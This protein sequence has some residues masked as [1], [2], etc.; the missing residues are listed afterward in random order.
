MLGSKLNH[1]STRPP[2]ERWKTLG[3]L[4]SINPNM[5]NHYASQSQTCQLLKILKNFFF[6]NKENVKSGAIRLNWY[7]KS[8]SIIERSYIYILY[9]IYVEFL[10]SHFNDLSKFTGWAIIE[11]LS[12]RRRPRTFLV[13]WGQ[14]KSCKILLWWL[15]SWYGFWFAITCIDLNV[16]L[17][18]SIANPGSQTNNLETVSVVSKQV[19]GSTRNIFFYYYWNTTRGNSSSAD[20]FLLR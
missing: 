16:N 20:V 9:H 5:I 15:S 11:E 8:I 10:A 7:P 4:R 6:S 17:D 19:N 3:H 2:L 14:R 12:I 1:V 18:F 13:S